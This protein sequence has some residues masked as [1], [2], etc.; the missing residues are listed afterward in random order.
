MI[1]VCLRFTRSGCVQYFSLDGS[2]L[3]PWRH[4]IE[5]PRR[6]SYN[7]IFGRLYFTI[8]SLPRHQHLY[9]RLFFLPPLRY[10]SWRFT[11]FC[12]SYCCLCTQEFR[13]FYFCDDGCVVVFRSSRFDF[14]RGTDTQHQLQPLARALYATT[15]TAEWH[16]LSTRCARTVAPNCAIETTRSSFSYSVAVSPWNAC[17]LYRIRSSWATIEPRSTACVSRLTCVCTSCT[18]TSFFLYLS[19]SEIYCIYLSCWR[20]WAYAL[21]VAIDLLFETTT[22]TKKWKRIKWDEMTY[23]NEGKNARCRNKIENKAHAAHWFSIKWNRQRGMGE[24]GRSHTPKHIVQLGIGKRN[25]PTLMRIDKIK[26]KKKKTA[27][28]QF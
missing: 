18:R 7:T 5:W 26:W 14:V 22:T 9:R 13:L 25:P 8:V 19:A 15:F 21:C 1:L 24:G 20:V 23:K 12:V 4:L 11:D 10:I 27:E 16:K 3:V 17:N 2:E 6:R 28:N